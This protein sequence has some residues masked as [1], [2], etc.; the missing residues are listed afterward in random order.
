[1]ISFL[2]SLNPWILAV[3]LNTLLLG[4][5]FLLPKKLLTP[6]GYIARLDF[7]GLNL[8]M[9]GMARLRFGD[10]LFLSGIGS[11]AHWQ[12]TEGS[13]RHCGEAWRGW[14]RKMFGVR[15]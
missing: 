12:G 3:G 6:A 2:S 15:R 5:A 8:G 10:V 4:I 13:R 7:G 14:V 1:M 11:D 9:F